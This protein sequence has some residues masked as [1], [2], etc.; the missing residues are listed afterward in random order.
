MISMVRRLTALGAIALTAA[1][2]PGAAGAAEEEVVIGM[3][4]MT[5]E[6]RTYVGKTGGEVMK[7]IQ[8]AQKLTATTSDLS[9]AARETEKALALVHSAESAS[10]TLKLREEIAGLLHHHR[11][12]KAKAD[13]VLPV[14][15]VL[16][17]ISEVKGVDVADVRTSLERAKGKLAEGATVEAEADLVEAYQGVGYLEIDLPLQATE[18]RL[19]AA[20]VALAQRDTGNAN[21]ALA[22]AINHTKTWTAMAESAEVEADVAD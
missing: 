21:A 5:Q 12:K 8:E 22:D 18:A 1:L 13:D 2:T 20:R 11:T 16:N 15:G 10:P 4:A 17:E 14:M 19:I 7:H 3:S 9:G 6:V